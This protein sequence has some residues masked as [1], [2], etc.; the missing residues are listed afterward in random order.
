MKPIQALI[1]NELE[2]A[3]RIDLPGAK[4]RGK[5]LDGQIALRAELR[6]RLSYR[7]IALPRRC[8]LDLLDR[9]APDPIDV[10]AERLE[11]PGKAMRGVGEARGDVG[12]RGDAGDGAVH[13][14]SRDHLREDLIALPTDQHWHP[15]E[16]KEAAFGELPC[17]LELADGGIEVGQGVHEQQPKYAV[18]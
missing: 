3:G 7:R 5:L 13:L 1:N 8:L 6:G 18:G 10:R 12:D 4:R 2:A 15:L 17:H 9:L 16:V 14:R 11:R